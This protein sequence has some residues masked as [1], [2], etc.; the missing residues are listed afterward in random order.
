M[1][2]SVFFDN[3]KTISFYDCVLVISCVHVWVGF[4][5]MIKK[6]QQSDWYI[7]LLYFSIVE[8]NGGTLS[9]FLTVFGVDEKLVENAIELET[10]FPTYLD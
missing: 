6:W 9:T 1:L 8:R 7:F 2:L 5:L 10:Y 3:Q 4:L